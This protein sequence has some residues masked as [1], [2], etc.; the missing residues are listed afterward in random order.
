MELEPNFIDDSNTSTYPVHV[1]NRTTAAI[2]QVLWETVQKEVQPQE[3]Q[4]ANHN[5][6]FKLKGFT[7][8][9]MDV[10]TYVM[11]GATNTEIAEKLG[12]SPNTV[13]FHVKNIFQ[14]LQVKNRV[15]LAIKFNQ[16]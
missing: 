4:T 8:R 16:V 1:I 10:L 9:E 13:K 11:T 14:K 15:E 7:A 3:L 2:L 6:K 5:I 12:I